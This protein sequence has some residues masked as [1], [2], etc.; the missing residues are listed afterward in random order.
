M[1]KA[2]RPAGKTPI[3]L[4]RGGKIGDEEF[5]DKARL[6]LEA[7]VAGSLFGRNLWQSPYEDGLRMTAKL[8]Q[9]IREDQT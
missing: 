5:L 6:A 3:S 8:R 4:S 1:D 7:R 9:V 2:A